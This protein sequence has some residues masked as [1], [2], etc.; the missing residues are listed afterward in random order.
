MKKP[1]YNTSEQGHIRRRTVVKTL[2]KHLEQDIQAKHT[3][4]QNTLHLLIHAMTG[5]GIYN[6]KS[7]TE[8]KR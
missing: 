7:D 2:M 6:P 5:S 8:S 4:H 1:S 3:R